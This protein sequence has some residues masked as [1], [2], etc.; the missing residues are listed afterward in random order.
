MEK[1]RQSITDP[2]KQEGV[3][4]IKRAHMLDF[5]DPDFPECGERDRDSVTAFVSNIESK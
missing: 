5:L 2:Q 1:F 3:C 4:T